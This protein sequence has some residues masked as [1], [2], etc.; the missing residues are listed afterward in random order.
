[1]SDLDASHLL[2]GDTTFYVVSDDDQPD[3]PTDLYGIWM[4]VAVF[5]GFIVL[6]VFIVAGIVVISRAQERRKANCKKGE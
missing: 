4:G 2:E 5:C 1:M 6:A 3:T